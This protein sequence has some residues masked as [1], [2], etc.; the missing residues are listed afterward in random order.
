MLAKLFYAPKNQCMQIL[1]MSSPVSRC[2]EIIGFD[3][4]EKLRM[5]TARILSKVL[6]YND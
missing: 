1:N 4:L 6:D 5:G 3:G 2:L